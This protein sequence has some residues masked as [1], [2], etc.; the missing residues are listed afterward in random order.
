[1]CLPPCAFCILL[2]YRL[3][4][5]S[6]TGGQGKERRVQTYIHKQDHGISC[7]A[8]H[9]CSKGRGGKKFPGEGK[10]QQSVEP[11]VYPYAAQYPQNGAGNGTGI[12]KTDKALFKKISGKK[13]IIMPRLV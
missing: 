10:L 6:D 12:L 7:G 11:Q 13:P 9:A 3:L 4:L 1:M 5:P 8:Y 2:L